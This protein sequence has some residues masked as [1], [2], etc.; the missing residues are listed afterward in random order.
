MRLNICSYVTITL[1]RCDPQRMSP[2]NRKSLTE[3]KTQELYCSW[4]GQL[5]IQEQQLCN[6]I[7]RS[8]FATSIPAQLPA[9][10]D[11]K[12][13]VAISELRKKFPEAVFRRNSYT[14][15]EAN[16][17]R[18]KHG[19]NEPPAQVGL[20]LPSLRQAL[21][22]AAKDEDRGRGPLNALVR[23][24]IQALARLPKTLPAASEAPD[25]LPLSFELDPDARSEKCP[26]SSY[27]HLQ[28]YLSHPQHYTLET[29]AALACLDA[30]SPSPPRDGGPVADDSSGFPLD[31]LPP[32]IPTDGARASLRPR[33]ATGKSACSEAALKA[34]LAGDPLLQRC[35][36]RSSRLLGASATKKWSPLKVLSL[37]ENSKKPDQNVAKNKPVSPLSLKRSLSAPPLGNSSG[38]T[39]DFSEPTL[40]LKNLQSPL[41]RKRGA[42]VLSAEFVRE[43]RT[44]SAPRAPVFV[45]QPRSFGKE[46]APLEM[47]ERWREAPKHRASGN[48]KACHTEQHPSE[49]PRNLVSPP[50]GGWR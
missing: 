2:L 44:E 28:F 20:V 48:K 38:R 49:R 30:P 11:I 16:D 35:K 13:V 24:H 17:A 42:Q 33:C 1:Q 46:T 4:K 32:E 25:P 29:S 21:L 5:L 14:D 40:K 9:R 22:E 37:M 18:R 45:R 3:C 8:P 31:P 6:I 36:R 34:S 43:T 19:K 47:Q 27:G 26:Q 15:H 23:R 7:L 12:H 10:L 41:R 39:A 50:G